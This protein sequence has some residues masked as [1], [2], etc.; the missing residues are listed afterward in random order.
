MEV[1]TH[2]NKQE[3]AF[4]FN[5]AGVM[6]PK[7]KAHAPVRILIITE[8]QLNYSAFHVHTLKRNYKCTV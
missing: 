8:R 6:P 3:V 2:M 5:V 1:R 4:N 7:P